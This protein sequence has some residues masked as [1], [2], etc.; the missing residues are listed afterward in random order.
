MGI[1]I[2]KEYNPEG[3]E[4][5]WYKIWLDKKYFHA[6]PN[7]EGEPFTIVIPPPNI[8]GSLHI[9][10]A[11]NST[12]Q[13]ILIRYKR[14]DGFNTLW[15]PGVDHAGIATQTVVERELAKEGIDRKEIGR[16]KFLEKIWEWREKYGDTIINQ[17]KRLGASC[18]WDRLRFTMDEGF[19][20][21]VKHAFVKLY[22]E[23][24]IYRGNYIINWC[25]RCLTALSDLEVDFKEEDGHLYYIKYPLAENTDK[26]VTVATTRPE[27]MLGDTAVAVHPDDNRFKDFVGKEVILPL[28]ERKIPV[29]ADEYVDLEFGTGALKITPAHD[30]NDFEVGKKHNL[31]VIKI[32]DNH[33][34]L[35]GEIPEKYIGLDRYKAREIIVKE[36][37]E[38]GYLEKTEHLN[39]MVGQCYRCGT[40]VEPNLSP[41][42]FIKTK[43]LA[44]D[45][46]TAIKENKTK[47]TPKMWEKTYFNWMENIRDWCISRQI[48][49]GHRIPVYTCNSCGWEG[50]SEDDINTCPK[51]ESNNI[52]QEE[53]VL[54]T[55]F[56]SGLWPLGTLGWPE[57]TEELKKYYPTS[58]QITGF[59]ILFF[60]VARMMMF[61]I[62]FGGEIPFKDIYLHALIRDENGLKMSKTKGN[63]IDP[64]VM[65]DK[66]GA[67]ALR[68][69]LTAL[70]A[71]GRDIK[72][73]E[74]VIVGYKAFANKIWNA[75]RFTLMNLEGFNEEISVDDLTKN[76]NE[77]NLW[78]LHRLNLTIGNVRTL[79]DKF[80]FNDAAKE[81]YQFFWDEFCDWYLELS[82]P[83]LYEKK[84][85]RKEKI[86]TQK[87][88]LFVLQN[89]L[90]L[91][92]PFMPF[93]TEE[94][95]SKLPSKEAESI[96]ISKFPETRENF[97]NSQEYNDIEFIKG[98][99]KSIRNIRGETNIPVGMKIKVLFKT[100]RKELLTDSEIF[101]S[102][103]AKI[104]DI[105][106]IENEEGIKAANSIFE[107]TKI[108]IPLEGVI[109]IDKELARL[110]KE[111]KNTIN[112][113]T[114]LSKKLNNES[115]LEK[116]PANIIE[117]EKG[118]LEK[119]RIKL[120]NINKHL[121]ILENLK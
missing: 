87:T 36:L 86:T 94:I 14:M 32:F 47:I 93:L 63:V 31:P 90:K 74:K 24:L 40:V 65:I 51:C 27:T 3:I 55:W 80:H 53:D 8:T 57:N 26:Y 35:N 79:L 6:D 61:G 10:H 99:I 103:L 69:T 76:S 70:A 33:A 20:K 101:I 108:F 121:K 112:E 71:Q 97:N 115:F 73:S 44:K 106:F 77:I 45:A 11:L 72:L 85:D 22:D 54:D 113:V 21:A 89:S 30:F 96:M 23:G 66:Y 119:E 48:W 92:H 100:N 39:H 12:L 111:H 116:A 29:I 82:K 109:D 105:E 41:Q 2:D 7:N 52:H 64:L 42:W 59:D 67:D 91:L 9:G 1:E 46:I 84:G 15:I 88:L 18:D 107:Q 5:K 68:F 118:K 117:K 56:S 110:K 49:W 4:E 28:T 13:D 75:S 19:S 16:E 25:P 50:A 62:K 120:E 37:Q 83:I 95:W 38:K 81:I 78:I 58:I 104:S 60:W 98:V 43:P 114:K 34:I 102:Q 17:L